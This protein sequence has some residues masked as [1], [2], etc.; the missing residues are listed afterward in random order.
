MEK[1][2]L[3]LALREWT[4]DLRSPLMWTILIGV[5]AILALVGPFETGI[6]LNLIERLAYWGLVATGSYLLGSLVH[7]LVQAIRE[8]SI[9]PSWRDALVPGLLSGAAILVFV[10]LVNLITFEYFPS[11]AEWSDFA[12]VTI[13][14]SV[15]VSLLLSQIHAA[16]ASNRREE[17]QVPPSPPFAGPPPILAR[18]PLEKRG[19]LLAIRVEDHYVRVFTDAGE[20]L[21]LMRLSDA[22]RETGNVPGDQVH[23]SHWVNF[24]AVTSAKRDGAR[25]ILTVQSG[26]EVPV[27]RAN[28]SKI[29]EAGLLP[30]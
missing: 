27:S 29:K 4:Q 10:T 7:T 8:G 22:V 3:Q 13:G 12:L 25:A 5:S 6:L 23:R 26:L 1:R 15:I 14:V 2:K 17:P 21:I 16:L 11:K 18:L 20:E 28:M 19:T 9:A 30:R 24:D